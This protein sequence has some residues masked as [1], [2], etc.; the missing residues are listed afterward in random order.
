MPDLTPWLKVKARYEAGEGVALAVK[1]MA[2]AALGEKFVKPAK[3]VRRPDFRDREAG[4]DSFDD[5][6]HGGMVAL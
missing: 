1:R 6:G 5:V 4:D 3:P 2:E